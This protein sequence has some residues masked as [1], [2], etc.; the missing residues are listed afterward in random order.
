MGISEHPAYRTLIRSG[1]KIN[2]WN[3]TSVARLGH[4]V[5]HETQADNI[6][7]SGMR[8]Q[9]HLQE[10]LL[11]DTRMPRAQIHRTSIYPSSIRSIIVRL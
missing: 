8:F 3:L 4:E 7:G 5:H 10:V 1:I 11:F 6:P 2:V 9:I